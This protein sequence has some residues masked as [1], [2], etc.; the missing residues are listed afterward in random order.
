M[1]TL[2][3]SNHMYEYRNCWIGDHVAARRLWTSA[4]EVA[5]GDD[6]PYVLKKRDLYIDSISFNRVNRF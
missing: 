2:A 1:G 4:L 6:T 3:K 5:E